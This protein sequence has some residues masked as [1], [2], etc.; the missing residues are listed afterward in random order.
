M[1]V[2]WTVQDRYGNA[3]YL[4]RERWDYI[5]TY[6]DELDGLLDDVLDTLRKGRRRQ[7]ALDPA[8]YKYYRACPA[9]PP[10]Y[11]TIVVVVKLGTRL[12]PEDGF[13]PNNF[14]I[15][16]WGVHTVGKR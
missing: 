4:T 3:I 7:E 14:V 8:R 5:L 2:K 15:T 1:P 16:A 12:L 13:E 11:N 9:L 10:G 6:H